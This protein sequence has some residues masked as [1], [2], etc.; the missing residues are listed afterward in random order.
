MSFD[1]KIPMGSAPN[2]Q[3]EIVNR[4]AIRWFKC[5][6]TLKPPKNAISFFQMMPKISFPIWINKG[7]SGYLDVYYSV[8]LQASILYHTLTGM[9]RSFPHTN[10]YCT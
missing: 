7:I 5:K 3:K 8:L 4:H 9:F 10:L 2:Y 6:L 1:K